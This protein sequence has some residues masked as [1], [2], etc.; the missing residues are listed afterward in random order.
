M[1][2]LKYKTP[3]EDGSPQFLG[4][5]FDRRTLLG[6]ETAVDRVSEKLP[7]ARNDHESRKFIANRIIK[8]V[9]AGSSTEDAM[10]RAG[11][12]AV[13]ELELQLRISNEV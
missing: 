10:T 13:I 9:L 1:N 4:E 3:S 8:C 2:L 12:N 5:I 6:M 7:V 11:L